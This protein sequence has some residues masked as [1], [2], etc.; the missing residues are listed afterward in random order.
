MADKIIVNSI[1]KKLSFVFITLILL[2]NCTI[3]NNVKGKSGLFCISDY[4][5]QD[6]LKLDSNNTFEAESIFR[7]LG[8]RIYYCKGKWSYVSK[9][10]I[11]L[12]CNTIDEK[13]LECTKFGIIPFGWNPYY[14]KAY[15]KLI[16]KNKVI[17]FQ[18]GGAKIVL[19]SDWCD[20]ISMPKESFIIDT[21]NNAERIKQMKIKS[22]IK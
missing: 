2:H 21:T 12:E 5:G 22:N 14:D 4:N 1:M 18:E 17:V 7:D 8:V 20:C 15:I 10:K 3:N 9:R 11:I 6:I 19:R 16:S 13:D